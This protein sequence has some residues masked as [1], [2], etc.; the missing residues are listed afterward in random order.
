MPA[1]IEKPQDK[2]QSNREAPEDNSIRGAIKSALDTHRDDGGELPTR[3][4]EPRREKEDDDKVDLKDIKVAKKDDKEQDEEIKIDDND[5]QDAGDDD[6]DIQVA[7]DKEP[8]EK[9]TKSQPSVQG[10]PNEIAAEWD[11]VPP[12]VKAYIEK[13]HKETNDNRQAVEQTK[14]RYRDMDAVLQRYEPAIRQFGVTPAV[15]V[16]RLF[17]W[18]DGLAGPHKDEVAKQL[19][20]NFGINLGQQT[21]QEQQYQYDSQTGQPITQQ[22]T[23]SVKDD[24]AF[25]QMQ[26]Q[27]AQIQ[28]KE[29]QA[30]EVAAQTTVN[31]WAGLQQDGSFKNKPHFGKVRAKMTS[32]LATGEYMTPANTLDLDR[33]YDDACYATSDVRNM[34]TQEADKERKA[35]EARDRAEKARKA[36]A[37]NASIK[38]S[39]QFINSGNKPTRPNGPVSIRDSIQ[40]AIDETRQAN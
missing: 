38:P 31:N 35:Q 4:R 19:L 21:Q 1:P 5:K 39:A 25:K 36:K 8:K 2:S 10:L 28:S 17:Q 15:T 3:E 26:S 6:T 23:F 18:M 40:S 27:L 13:F 20:E 37:A 24:P 34:I 29:Q 30:S 22:T 16:D 32:L 11:N 33:V 14:A 12:A 7:A 9:K